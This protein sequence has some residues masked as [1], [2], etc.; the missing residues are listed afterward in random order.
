MTRRHKRSRSHNRRSRSRSNS[1]WRLV[2][3]SLA[4]KRSALMRQNSVS[5][6]DYHPDEHA[7]VNDRSYHSM[8]AYA[9]CK[10]QTPFHT[11]NLQRYSKLLCDRCK[12]IYILSVERVST[13]ARK[14][15]RVGD[16]DNFLTSKDVKGKRMVLFPI[17]AGVF[18]CG[19]LCVY[20]CSCVL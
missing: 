8:G 20:S 5:M 18:M 2:G 19:G 13:I 10:P 3:V 7:T 16:A 15:I 11:C 1:P 9:R 4:V 17:H 12:D 6:N 14:R